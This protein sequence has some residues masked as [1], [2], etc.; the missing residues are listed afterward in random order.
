MLFYIEVM[1][2]FLLIIK[3]LLK[4][5]WHLLLKRN[6]HYSI[7]FWVFKIFF[8][9]LRVPSIFRL[10]LKHLI[11]LA[12]LKLICYRS[13]FWKW[14]II[15]NK[16][17]FIAIIFIWFERWFALKWLVFILTDIDIHFLIVVLLISVLL[18]FGTFLGV[19]DEGPHWIIHCIWLPSRSHWCFASFL[20]MFLFNLIS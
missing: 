10:N 15:L 7:H 13:L 6:F 2:L 16:W 20:L 3:V 5:I 19:I 17:L 4:F 1:C 11:S 8:N 9:L 14:V 18:V 12:L